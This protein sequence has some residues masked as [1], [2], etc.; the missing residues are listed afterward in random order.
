MFYQV[1]YLKDPN[2][3]LIH[4]EEEVAKDGDEYYDKGDRSEEDCPTLV[5]D[6]FASKGIRSVALESYV[7]II[8]KGQVF[9]W[10]DILD[11]VVFV[12]RLNFEKT[13]EVIE[14]G[15]P[16]QYDPADDPDEIC[17]RSVADHG[18]T[19]EM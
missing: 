5:K 6:L 18:E 11:R 4:I 7:I 17:P 3:C 10:S 19:Q 15:E 16:I 2:A 13:G 9:D 8:E 12:L 1:E 14:K